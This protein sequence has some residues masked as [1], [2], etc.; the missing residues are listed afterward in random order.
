MRAGEFLAII[1]AKARRLLW[2]RRGRRLMHLAICGVA[3]LAAFRWLRH[4]TGHR[5]GGSGR[6]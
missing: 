4:R 6:K 5:M 2:L 3:A 1:L